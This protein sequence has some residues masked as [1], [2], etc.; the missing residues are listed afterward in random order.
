MRKGRFG[1]SGL[2]FGEPCLAHDRRDDG[3]GVGAR[4]ARLLIQGDAVVKHVDSDRADV[5]RTHEVLA[6]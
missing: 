5:V 3:I 6:L 4:Q 1:E 2:L